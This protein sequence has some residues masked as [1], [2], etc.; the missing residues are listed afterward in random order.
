M[1]RA[2]WVCLA[3]TALA[4]PA[5]AQVKVRVSKDVVFAAEQGDARAQTKLGYMHERGL[6]V[7]QDYLLAAMWYH[8]AAVQGEP[9]GQHRLGI[10]FNKGFGVQLDLIE[11]YKWLNLAAA[12]VGRNERDYYT[13]MRN[14][15]ASKLTYA[16]LT[17]AQRRASHWQP[18]LER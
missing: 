4:M 1:R 9:H 18:V 2:L 5:E 15:V 6:R 3:L 8:R 14:A 13:R 11:A 10:L 12:G 7:P 16:E 17:E